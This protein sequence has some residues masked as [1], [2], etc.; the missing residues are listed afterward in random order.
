MGLFS[1]FVYK[2]K[3]GQKFWLHVKERK[4]VSLYFF[5][6]E[7]KNALS[8]VPPGFEVQENPITG[9]PYLKKGAFFTGEKKK[10]QEN[11]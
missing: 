5:S 6:K 7:P 11:K 2:S 9:M 8:D 1:D 3:K 4:G 10:K